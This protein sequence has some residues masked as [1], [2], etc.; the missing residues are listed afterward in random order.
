MMAEISQRLTQQ[1][2]LLATLTAA[3]GHADLAPGAEGLQEAHAGRE[4]SSAV[5][6]GERGHTDSGVMYDA[7]SGFSSYMPSESGG[8][9]IVAIGM[10]SGTLISTED[11]LEYMPVQVRHLSREMKS[12]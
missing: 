9:E 3:G 8:D 4:G 2:R 10:R 5:L 12:G 11:G 1:G 6:P 7:Q